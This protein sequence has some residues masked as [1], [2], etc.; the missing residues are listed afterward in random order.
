M[1]RPALFPRY[2][3]KMKSHLYIWYNSC[4]LLKIVLVLCM[5]WIISSPSC[6]QVW[7]ISTD[8]CCT[9]LSLLCG[10]VQDTDSHPASESQAGNTSPGQAGCPLHSRHF[11]QQGGAAG[12]DFWGGELFSDDLTPSLYWNDF[13]L[14]QLAFFLH[15]CCNRTFIYQETFVFFVHS[16]CRAAWTQTPQSSSSLHSSPWAI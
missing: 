16:L 11:Q 5:Q 2:S 1:P 4:S 9:C 12:T 8:V 7:S 6:A 13:Y 3:S 15:P 14:C 10:V